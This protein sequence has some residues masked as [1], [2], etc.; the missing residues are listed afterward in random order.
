MLP[1]A[2]Q[3]PRYSSVRLQI[4]ASSCP[5]R[6]VC[7]SSCRVPPDLYSQLP[8]A[9]RAMAR[10]AGDLLKASEGRKET[11]EESQTRKDDQALSP[12]ALEIPE[13][14]YCL[15]VQTHA[16]CSHSG[17]SGSWPGSFANPSVRLP[18]GAQRQ[19]QS[20]PGQPQCNGELLGGSSRTLG[21]NGS[22]RNSMDG[23]SPSQT[24][25]LALAA[26]P[27][28]TVGCYPE[29]MPPRRTISARVE[30]EGLF[31]VGAETAPGSKLPE[32]RTIRILDPKQSTLHPLIAAEQRGKPGCYQ[33]LGLDPALGTN[34]KVRHSFRPAQQLRD[35]QTGVTAREKE[36]AGDEAPNTTKHA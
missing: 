4:E 22:P 35:L 33:V 13:R 14:S 5:A 28:L 7:L 21:R 1:S 24:P 9:L 8:Y 32:E 26:A 27:Q 16:C 17:P 23:R 36:P 15:Q 2:H 30:T 19:V 20:T 12:K 18:G 34:R 31:R 3:L 10:S 6:M 11:R 25:V 29:P